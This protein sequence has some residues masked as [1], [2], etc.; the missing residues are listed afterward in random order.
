MRK[1][2]VLNG[3]RRKNGNT[4]KFIKSI[5]KHINSELFEIEYAF[6]QDF[7]IKPCSGCHQCFIN[8]K[9]SVKDEISLIQE[10]IVSADILIIASP[11]YLHYM[12]ADLKL[13]LDKLS[14][15]THLFKLQGKPVVVLSTCSTNGHNSVIDPLSNMMKLMGGNVIASAN[16]AQIPNQI[17]NEVWLE[18]VSKEI[19]DRICKYAFLPIQS[20]ICLDNVFKMTKSSILEQEQTSVEYDFLAGEVEYWK[21]TGMLEYDTFSEYLTLKNNN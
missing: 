6:P 18:E 15:W 10:K 8:I 2:F 14:H 20:T 4:I 13:I 16:A 3:S 19:S 21:E 7:K 9:C 5:L 12:T 1:I 11:V 17:N